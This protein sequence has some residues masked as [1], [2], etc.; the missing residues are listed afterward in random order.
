MK[1]CKILSTLLVFICF[2]CAGICNNLS[3]QGKYSTKLNLK[4]ASSVSA[5]ANKANS[6][7][8]DNPMQ[9]PL[10]N[11]M[12][13]GFMNSMMMQNNGSYSGE[14]MRKQQADY[15]KQQTQSSD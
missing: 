6:F 1:Y 5:Q 14:E 2:S 12:V 7:E 8:S 4:D 15:V 9:D 3:S 11:S 13:G 10:V